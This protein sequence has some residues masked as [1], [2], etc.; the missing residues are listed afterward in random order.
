MSLRLRDFWIFNKSDKTNRNLNRRFEENCWL[1]LF[2]VH[3]KIVS[4]AAYSYCHRWGF[5]SS[6]DSQVFFYFSL[7]FK[8][9][10]QKREE[11]SKTMKAWN[12]IKVSIRERGEKEKNSIQ[13][14]RAQLRKQRNKRETEQRKKKQRN[15]AG[16]EERLKHQ[17]GFISVC[18]SVCVSVFASGRTWQYPEWHLERSTQTDEDSLR[19]SVCVCVCVRPLLSSSCFPCLPVKQ[20]WTQRNLYFEWHRSLS[21]NHH[22]LCE[23]RNIPL[24]AA[25]SLGLQLPI[26]WVS[27][28]IIISRLWLYCDVHF[29]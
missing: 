23:V 10:N 17:S 1:Y 29:L 18:E 3:L 19:G 21:A 13:N 6:L 8:Q 14:Y 11:D 4:E 5:V 20:H 9:I 16:A 12:K 7:Y 26:S 25:V 27:S 2:E 24:N 22:V 28:L 15:Q